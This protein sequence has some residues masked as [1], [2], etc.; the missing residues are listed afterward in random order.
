MLFIS[1][2]LFSLQVA[3]G[4]FTQYFHDISNNDKRHGRWDTRT[5]NK[6]C[7]CVLIDLSILYAQKDCEWISP[8]DS[9]S[10]TIHHPML[11]PAFA[12]KLINQMSSI[13]L[14]PSSLSKLIYTIIAG[15]QY[16]SFYH[17]NDTL[18]LFCRLCI[19]V[20]WNSSLWKQWRTLEEAWSMHLCVYN[21]KVIVE[22]PKGINAFF[23]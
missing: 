10:V 22:N 19:C 23:L 3:H 18:S 9:Y 21:N 5:I 17:W 13:H 11:H 20:K 7:S 14:H 8:T 12:L 4:F 15:L 6:S 2:L 1:E 16:S